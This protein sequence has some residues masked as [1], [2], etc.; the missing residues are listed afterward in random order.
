MAAYLDGINSDWVKGGRWSMVYIDDAGEYRDVET[1]DEL[2]AQ[3]GID[4]LPF[5]TRLRRRAAV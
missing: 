4:G 5:G 3:L 1:A 2:L